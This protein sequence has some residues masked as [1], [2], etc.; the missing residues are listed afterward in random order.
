M[1]QNT[2]IEKCKL[3]HKSLYDYSLVKYIGST[4]KVKIKCNNCESVF[5]QRASN[6]LLGRGCPFCNGSSINDT[7]DIFINKAIKKH[8]NKYDYSQVVYKNS[9]TKIKIYCNTCKDYFSQR[10][11]EHING[12]G[13]P[14]CAH[15]KINDKLF[16]KVANKIHNNLYDYELIN[17]KNYNSKIKIIC[18]KHGVFEQTPANHL[19]GEGCPLCVG[20]NKT[21]DY[22]INE[23]KKIHGETF[24]YSLVRYENSNKKIKIK[25]NKCNNIFEQRA[26]NHLSGIGC[27]I[28]KESKGEK[29][30]RKFLNEKHVLFEQQKKF[31]KCINILP[32]PFDFYLPEYNICIEY[33]GEQHYEIINFFGG[34]TGFSKRQKLDNI[35]NK[36]CKDNNINLI[37]IRFDDNIDEKLLFLEK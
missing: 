5:E 1:T 30:I 36:Y 27:P 10:P 16:I 4:K 29:K 9:I 22:F 32:L 18:A 11:G 6:H 28:C 21:T 20:K 26:S 3:K 13:C 37:R 14:K 17:Y 23:L 12:A 15:K 35:K 34:E 24:D 25:C 31:K 8:K 7:Q 19:K 2:Y 33:D